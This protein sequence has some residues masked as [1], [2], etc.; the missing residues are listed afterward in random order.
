MK[1]VSLIT[2]KI[3]LELPTMKMLFKILVK[4]Y[5]SIYK[6]IHPMINK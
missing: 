1:G 2:N 4:I 5:E 3:L 6:R